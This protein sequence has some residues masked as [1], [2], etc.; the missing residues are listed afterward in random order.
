[1]DLAAR[2]GMWSVK[3]LPYLRRLEYIESTG[4]QYIVS[5]VT[6]TNSIRIEAD[7]KFNENRQQYSGLWNYNGRLQFGT[8]SGTLNI[9]IGSDSSSFSAQILGR[10]TFVLDCKNRYA[11]LSDVEG[12]RVSFSS[13]TI[14]FDFR[15]IPAFAQNTIL[16]GPLGGFRNYCV[17]K[18]YG[19]RIFDDSVLVANYIPVM[20]F[21]NTPEFFDEI[22]QTFADRHGDF[23]YG[24]LDASSAL[25]ST[26]GGV[27]NA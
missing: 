16:E 1:M 26:R 19:L 14:S 8:S 6:A 4:S 24:E 17:A 27:L 9:G 2:T 5:H 13:A 10:H 7:F 15:K 22:T 3:P 12:S 25:V 11:E 18:G 21:D 20:S 23:L